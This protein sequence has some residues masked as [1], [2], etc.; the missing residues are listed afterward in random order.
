MEK[1]SSAF[2][3]SKAWKNCRSAYAQ[4]VGGLCEWCLKEG[5]YTPGEIVHHK[6]FITPNNITDPSITLNFDNLVLL[7][8]DHHAE[9]H[10]TPKRYKV[11]AMGR[12]TI[13]GT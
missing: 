2:Y 4:S 1:W 11:D 10:S 8:R 12:V 13:I 5:K 9:A 6:T 7:C 3:N